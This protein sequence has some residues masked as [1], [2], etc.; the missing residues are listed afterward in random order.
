LDTT[1]A[2]SND[3]AY[4][5]ALPLNKVAFT[6]INA[7]PVVARVRRFRFGGSLRPCAP[8]QSWRHNLQFAARLMNI[9]SGSPISLLGTK[10]WSPQALFWIFF[11]LFFQDDAT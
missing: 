1:R 10:V 7:L 5:S 2:E 6:L 8:G 4:L 3:S 9:L 11:H